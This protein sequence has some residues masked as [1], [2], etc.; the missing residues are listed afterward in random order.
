MVRKGFGA[1]TILLDEITQQKLNML[2]EVK[3]LKNFINPDCLEQKYGGT[4]PNITSN[5]FPPN[6][7]IPGQELIT[8]EE[9]YEKCPQHFNGRIDEI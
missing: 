9:L 7:E 8:Q 6:M 2:K 1:V 4:I 5:F 3:D